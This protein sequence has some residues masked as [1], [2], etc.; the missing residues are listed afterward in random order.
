[1]L[2]GTPAFDQLVDSYYRAWWNLCPSVGSRAGLYE[3]DADLESPSA[4]LMEGRRRQVAETAA[5]CAK[6]QSPSAGTLEEL[7][8]MA[9]G[10]H[11]AITEL[12]LGTIQRWRRDASVPLTDAVESLFELLMRR[13]LSDADTVRAIAVRLGKVPEY[14]RAGRSRIDNPVGLWVTMAEQSVPGSVELIRDAVMPLGERH[15]SLQGEL[16]AA[17]RAAVDAVLNYGEWLRTLREKPLSDDFAVGEETLGRLIKEWHGLTVTPAEVEELGWSLVQ[18]YRDELDEH[19]QRLDRG[20]SWQTALAHARASFTQRSRDVLGG[21]RAITRDLRDRLIRDDLLDLPPGE[22]CKVIPTPGFLRALVP[23]AA[24]SNPGPLDRR[25]IGIFYVT[26]PD[27]AVGEEIYRANVGQHYGIEETCVHEAYP[28]HHVQ[29][30]WAN[31]AASR[32]RQMAEHIIFMEGWTLYCEQWMIDQ[33]W[34][35]DPLLKI[36]YLAGQLWR[37]YRMVIDVGI[38]TRKLSV[39]AAVR[40]LVDGLGFTEE[41]ARTELNWYTQSP[42]VPMS[43]MLGKR[44]TLALR[45]EFMRTPGATLKHF[46]RRL[47]GFGS[48]PQRWLG[49]HLAGC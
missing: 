39:A 30:C 48:L 3:Y 44:E 41:R 9:F 25:Q 11:L 18:H 42:A 13:D 46:H 27:R 1:M 35:A 40:M 23:T 38:H 49:P 19:A 21:Y 17:G 6:L 12:R 16:T 26:E 28:G 36:N 29:L 31:Q 33:E 5:A 47:L 43:Y 14:L 15:P 22:S 34:F 2:A 10:S 7:D 8:R 20:A 37:A 24:Y 4:T 32:A 45:D